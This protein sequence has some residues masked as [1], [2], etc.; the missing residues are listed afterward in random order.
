MH[1]FVHEYENNLSNIFFHDILHKY[2]KDLNTWTVWCDLIA[3]K[4]TTTTAL[5]IMN[6]NFIIIIFYSL[7]Q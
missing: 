5:I 6:N 3:E 7:I 4:K 2:I 1:D